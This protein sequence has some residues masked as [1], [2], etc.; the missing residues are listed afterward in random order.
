MT[1]TKWSVA[2]I[3]D[4]LI[5]R[6]DT[7]GVTP[8]RRVIRNNEYPLETRLKFYFIKAYRAFTY[9]PHT[10]M[11][12]ESGIS[13]CEGG[14]HAQNTRTKHK[15]EELA[16]IGRCYVARNMRVNSSS[17]PRLWPIRSQNAVI[18]HLHTVITANSLKKILG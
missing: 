18:Y 5:T 13:Q 7:S 12:V 15:L 8:S 11:I 4:P 2:I 10:A 16:A 17:R 3:W 14:R 9:I 1:V 6:G